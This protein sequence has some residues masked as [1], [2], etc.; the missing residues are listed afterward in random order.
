MLAVRN[1]TES[2]KAVLIPFDYN[3]LTTFKSN[4]ELKNPDNVDWDTI[5]ALPEWGQLKNLIPAFQ[6]LN[7]FWSDISHPQPYLVYVG[8]APGNNLAVL[9]QA[10][11][12]FNY[13]LYDTAAFDERLSSSPSAKITFHNKFFDQSDIEYWKEIQKTQENVFMMFDIRNPK[14]RKEL[15]EDEKN[16]I[17]YD[18]LMFQ[19]LCVKEIFPV[20]SL[21]KVKFP[22]KIIPDTDKSE[23]ETHF[24]YLDGVVY[25]HAY[26][27]KNSKDFSLVPH[28]NVSLRLWNIEVMDWAITHHNAVIRQNLYLS[29]FETPDKIFISHELG[30]KH[31]FD[32]IILTLTIRDY[33]MKF[34]PFTSIRYPT[35]EELISCLSAIIKNILPDHRNRLLPKARK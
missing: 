1:K 26:T 7:A 13:H 32:G 34:S 6:F 20:K 30:I 31:N 10:F 35:L 22:T 14:Y 18:D 5:K 29:D 33:L 27:D 19:M 11:P 3:N 8:A 21:L 9:I 25:R 2:K 28:D 12:W 16:K 24:S 15:S 17:L 23:D 4:S